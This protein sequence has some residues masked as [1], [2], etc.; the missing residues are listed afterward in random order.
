MSEI[1]HG[2]TYDAR[3][4][5]PGWAAAGFADGEW[6]KVKV[7]DHRKDDLIAPAGP[8][9]RRIEELKPVKVLR[10]PAGDT[11]VDL[12]QNMV[13]WVRLKAEGPAGT[14]ITLRHAEVLDKAGNFYTANLRAAK[15][16][17]RYTMKGGGPETFEPHFTFFGFRYVAVAG[18]PGE[19]TPESLTGVVVHSEM[20]RASAFE[21]SKPLVNQLQHN[22]IWGQKGNF[23][24]VPTDCPQRDE[25][26]GW[27]GDAQAF[28]PTA[29]FNMDVAAFFTKW[30][31]DVAADQ[32]AS[33]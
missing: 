24:D 12:G 19:V 31:K 33:Q 26:L 1:Y 5:K 29:A 3:L 15:A 23:L 21:T 9:V 10:T 18:Y 30:L 14:T 13:G 17:M 16:T 11:V 6:S 32:F 20:A 8:P 7:A 28:S 22:I 2:E 25:R 27:T 4:E